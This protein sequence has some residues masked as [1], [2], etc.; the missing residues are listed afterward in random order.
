M[1]LS[2]MLKVEKPSEYHSDHV[3]FDENNVTLVVKQRYSKDFKCTAFN[4]TS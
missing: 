1:D 3:K 2:T 4:R